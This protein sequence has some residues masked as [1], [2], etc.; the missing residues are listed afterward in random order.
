MHSCKYHDF[1]KHMGGQTS[2]SFTNLLSEET[3]PNNTPRNPKIPCSNKTNGLFNT[4][5]TLA[6]YKTRH[7]DQGKEATI[8]P[9]SPASTLPAT[10]PA[11]SCTGIKRII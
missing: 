11:G 7:E 3:A 2:L 9:I 4:D 6:Y 10:K 1:N 8:Q 5:F